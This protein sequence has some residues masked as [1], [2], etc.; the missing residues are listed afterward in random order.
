MIPVIRLLAVRDGSV[1]YDRRV[2]IKSSQQVFDL[3]KPLLDHADREQFLVLALDARNRPLALH[4]LSVGTLT[5]SV[6]HPR[7][8]FK[9]AFLSNAASLIVCHNHP[10][11]DPQPSADDD[12]VTAK[13]KA[14]GDL[15]SVPVI[16]HVVIGESGYFSYADSGRLAMAR[17]P[18]E[19]RHGEAKP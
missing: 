12:A 6:I 18:L 15:L 4:Q 17:S 19:I 8:L 3:V 9:F 11:G 14:C 2:G 7:E 5:Q 13:L 16:D 10:S 1:P